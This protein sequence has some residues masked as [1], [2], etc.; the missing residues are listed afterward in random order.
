MKALDEVGKLHPFINVVV[1][2]FKTV[3]TLETKRR[4]NDKKVIALYVEMKDMIS[5]LVG[6]KTVKDPED[7]GPDGITIKGRLQELVKK[8]AKDMQDCANTCD[9]YSKM[10]VLAKVLKG[11]FWEGSLANFV[12]LFTKRRTEFEFALSIHIGRGVDEANQ[13]LDLLSQQLQQRRTDMILTFIQTY[14]PPDQRELTSLVEKKGGRAAVME[15]EN[16]LKELHSFESKRPSKG[17]DPRSL[18]AGHMRGGDGFE[19]LKQE[20]HSD[21]AT[22]ILGNLN[23]FERKFTMQQRQIVE[24]LDRVVT[25]ESDRVI[26]SVTSGPHDRILDQDLYAVWKDMAWRGSVK[27]RHLVLALRDFY[28]EKSEEI[29]RKEITFEVSHV[30]DTDSWALEWFTVKRLQPI[31]E[32][33]DDDAS[34]FITVAE[35]NRLTSTRPLDWSLPHWMAYWAIG[36]QMTASSYQDKIMALI[37]KMFTLKA[38]VHDANRRSVDKYLDDIWMIVERVVMS[39]RGNHEGDALQ[40]RFQ[41]YVDSEE[42]RIK[43]NLESI[44]YNIADLET[45]TLVT[46]QGR[47]EK[48][49]YFFPLLYLLLKRDC[50]IIRIAQ[51]HVLHPDE[52]WDS[53]ES[54]SWVFSAI[55]WRYAHLRDVFQ[56]QNLDLDQQFKSVACEL[57]DYYH[58][59][60]SINTRENRR[61]NPLCDVSYYSEVEDRDV[62]PEDVLLNYPLNSDDIF[63][64]G[65]YDNPPEYVPTEDD[66][67]AEEPLKPILGIWHCVVWRDEAYPTQAMFRLNFHI[68]SSDSHRC[69]STG[70]TPEGTS[71]T[72]VGTYEIQAPGDITYSFK[73]TYHTR[74]STSILTGSLSEDKQMLS[75]VRKD[76]SAMGDGYFM[77]S[78]LPADV[79]TFR[80]SPN[81]FTANKARALWR[82]ALGAIEYQISRTMFSW[83]FFKRRRDTRQRYLDLLAREF[84][85]GRPLDDAEKAEFSRCRQALTPADAR[86]YDT[87]YSYKLRTTEIHLGFICSVC[88]GVIGGTRTICLDCNVDNTV[89]ICDDPRCLASNVERRYLPSAH[90]P[91]HTV[92]KVRTMLHKRDFGKVE[93]GAI[94][95][96][97]RARAALKDVEEVEEEQLEGALDMEDRSADVVKGNLACIVCKKRVSKPCWYCVSCADDT[98]IC[99]SCDPKDGIQVGDHVKTHPL[100]KCQDEQSKDKPI[101]TEEKLEALETKYVAL[102]SK[103]DHVDE[104]LLHME[105]LMKTMMS[106]LGQVVEHLT[107]NAGR[108][109]SGSES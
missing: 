27:C 72:C 23:T 13:K 16:V 30:E 100:V 11:P 45:L 80:P 109:Q 24:E 54:V 64:Y 102:D 50:D 46:G 44:Q 67:K 40:E 43:K 59:A 36:W 9:A 66:L 1:L 53:A 14:V 79:L 15:D 88:G 51:K 90:L 82:F 21:P 99:L 84:D 25:R 31:I 41:S 29:K 19:E 83:S 32:A 106:K 3:Y 58:N 95:A 20:I 91:T 39:L 17:N 2:A 38:T 48:A 18:T 33:F 81:D 55:Y 12:T 98:F 4:A 34:G 87:I 93:S 70:V 94:D 10:K 78:R 61:N 97:E 85:Y 96:L 63:D 60:E 108:N 26:A 86:F 49:G 107:A 69:E 28:R 42:E 76:S 57:F 74:F 52:L 7:P 65:V 89:D 75:G 8:T 37:D 92:Y 5:V 73:I 68:D 35:A 62:E 56:Q 101:S 47:I 77:L 22:V 103:L 6:L 71:W 105:E 104:R